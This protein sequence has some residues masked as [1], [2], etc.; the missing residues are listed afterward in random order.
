MAPVHSADAD[1]AGAVGHGGVAD[2]TGGWTGSAGGDGKDGS[3]LARGWG[4]G[5]DW[6]RTAGWGSGNG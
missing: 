2:L 5:N 4:S 3:G 6:D 1:G